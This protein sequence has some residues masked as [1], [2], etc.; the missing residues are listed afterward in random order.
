[1]DYGYA[2]RIMVSPLGKLRRQSPTGSG[3]DPGPFEVRVCEG[4]GFSLLLVGGISF[5]P[6]RIF[7]FLFT[8]SVALNYLA[9]KSLP[10]SDSLTRATNGQ[11]EPPR[12]SRPLE[13]P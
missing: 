9:H 4:V 10:L 7:S 3:C 11:W 13:S 8:N 1:M 2:P 12:A 6:F 5:F